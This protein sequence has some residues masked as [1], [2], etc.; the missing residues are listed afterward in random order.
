MPL[1]RCGPRS[2]NASSEPT[3]R[4]FTPRD[5]D[6]SPFGDG[7]DPGGEMNRDAADVLAS[8][9]DLAGVD[10]GA[11]GQLERLELPPEAGREPDGSTGAVE[12]GEHAVSGAL[13]ES[14]SLRSQYSGPSDPGSS[15]NLAPAMCPAR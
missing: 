15:T 7:H 4:S 11:D 6:L 8:D 13:D 3:T 12:G 14:P 1:R 10:A 9:L 2:S 5:E